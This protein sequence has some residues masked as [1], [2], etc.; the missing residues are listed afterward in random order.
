MLR[1]KDLQYVHPKEEVV[2]GVYYWSQHRIF[3]T[4]VAFDVANPHVRQ[5]VAATAHLFGKKSVLVIEEIDFT[6]IAPTIEWQPP[7]AERRREFTED[8][9][10]ARNP[11]DNHFDYDD[12]V[13]LDFLEAASNLRSANYGLG[14]I[15]RFLAQK[16][17]GRIE[18][19]VS[20]TAS[21]CAAG[22]LT[23]FFVST[24]SPSGERGKFV[25]S[26]FSVATYRQLTTPFRK[27]GNTDELFSPWDFIRFE[28][29][30]KLGDAQ[31]VI[32]NRANRRMACW[33]TTDGKMIPGGLFGPKT[34]DLTFN[35]VFGGPSKIV[36][37]EVSLELEGDREFFLPPVRIHV[38]A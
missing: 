27:F 10:P 29:D 4:A 33:A 35:Q 11:D 25:V 18:S 7:D 32:E 2:D 3:P 36:E 20:T 16:I 38:T 9:A 19:A 5:F 17:A 22:L 37:L 26:P 6:K 21:V 13:Q 30:E 15:D 8:P 31:R 14:A 24:V 34:C 12:D 1:I 23:A 28:G